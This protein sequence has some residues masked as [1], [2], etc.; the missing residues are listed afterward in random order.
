MRNRIKK[1]N[2]TKRFLKIPSNVEVKFKSNYCFFYG[3]MG[4]AK[5]KLHDFLSIDTVDSK[6]CVF[7]KKIEFKKKELIWSFSLLNTTF[8][9]FRSYIYGVVN[10]FKKELVLVG[11]GYKAEYD[12]KSFVLKLS[13]GFSHLVKFNIPKG[14]LIKLFDNVNICIQGVSK[15]EVGKMALKIRDKRLPEVYKGNGIRYKNEIIKLKSPKK[16]K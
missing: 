12:A 5:H 3:P 6:L 13:L 2:N 1:Y 7:L 14:I 11:I 4:V 16:S 8:S 10:F 15:S 9:L